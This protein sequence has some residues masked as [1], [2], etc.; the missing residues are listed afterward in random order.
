MLGPNNTPNA[1]NQYRLTETRVADLQHIGVWF[2]PDL[3]THEIKETLVIDNPSAHPAQREHKADPPQAHD[4][5]SS[6]RMIERYL[7]QDEHEEPWKP[8]Q[9]GHQAR[10]K[11]EELL[12]CEWSRYSEIRD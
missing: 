4:D 8:E 5:R 10:G 9:N 6:I 12:R 3:K 7:K 2:K 11:S 1:N